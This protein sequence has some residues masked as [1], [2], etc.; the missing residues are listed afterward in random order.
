MYALNRAQ[1]IGHL[2]E[3]PQVRQ[4][5]TGQ[6]VG[7]LNVMTKQL[8]KTATGTQMTTA[9]HNV[10]VRSLFQAGSKRM[11]GRIRLRVK[12]AIRHVSRPMN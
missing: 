9:Y 3:D 7:D 12:S 11:N 6:S 1:I 8:I 2:T 10:V 5:P 4:T